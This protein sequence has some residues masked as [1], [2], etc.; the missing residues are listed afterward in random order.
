MQ[1]H[2]INLAKKIYLKTPSKALRSVYFRTFCSVVRNRKVQTSVDGINYELD[3]GEVID[4]SIYLNRYEPDTTAA[5]EKFCLSG[6]TVFDIGANI[7]A[8]TLRLG[9]LAGES[10][11]VYA[12]EPTDYAYQRLVRNITLNQFNVVPV[13]IALSDENRLRQKV[14]FRSSWPTK[15]NPAENECTVD[16]VRLD[17][18]WKS[19]N[20]SHV[21]QIKIDVDG[22]EHTVIRG[23]E[24]LLAD[25]HPLM[26][27]EV[28]GPNFADASKNPF[29]VLKRLGYRFFD[30]ASGE[31]YTTVDDLKAMVSVNGKLLDHSF[32]I[33]ARC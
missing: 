32:N 16:F 19:E 13:Q 20:P 10:G 29:V 15:G 4:V 18:W 7:G 14:H 6:F 25:Q 17:V 22:N 30:I 9:R 26:L 24:S 21:D 5:I 33:V 27:I 8:H 2:L 23:A 28:W 3:L 11:R 31:E 1:Q 12:F